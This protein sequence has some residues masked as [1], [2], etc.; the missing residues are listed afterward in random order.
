MKTKISLLFAIVF[1]NAS[2]LLPQWI[3]LDKN[4]PPDSKP[5]VHLISDDAAGTVIRVDLPG[6]R[7]NEIK[8][9]GKIYQSVEIGP[10]AGITSETGM[11]DIP[12]IAKILAIPDQGIVSVEVLEVGKK[13]VVEGINI[14]PARKSWIEGSPESPYLENDLVYHSEKLYPERLVKVEDPLIFRDFRIARVSIFPIQYSPAKQEIEAFST[15]TVRIKYGGG[16]GLNPKMTPDKPIAPSFDRLYKSIIFNYNEVLQRE[17]NG[18]VEGYDLMLCIMPDS[19]VTTFQQYADWNHKTGTFIHITKFSEIGAT[20]NNPTPIKDF[21]LNAYTSWAIPPTY[22]LLVGDA[23]VAPVKYITLDGWTFTYDD[24]FVELEG[25]D[26]I[27]ELMIGRFTNQGNV[28]LNI[29]ENKFIGYEKTPYITD[30]NWFRKGLVC[31]NDEYLSQILT[32]RFTAQE[33]LLKGNY[34]SVDSMYNGYP[35]PGNTTDIVNMINEGRGFLN[36]RGEGWYSG[37]AA[38]CFPLDVSDINSLS[39]GQKLTFVTSIGC[40][41]ANF[42]N[43]SANNFG[44]AWMEIGDV[45]APRGACAFL[46]PVSN[47]HTYYNNE[48][49]KGIYIGMFEEG[50]DSPGEAL[51][52]GKFRMYEIFGGAD[53]YVGYHYRIYHV[54]GDPSLHIWKDTP[55]NINV[56]YNDSIGVGSGEVNVTVTYQGSGLPVDGAKVCVSGDSVYTIGFTMSDGTAVLSVNPQTTGEL[57]FTVSGSNVIPFEG[58]IQV[59][60]GGTLAGWQWIET[61]Y[62]FTI[63][64]MSFPPGQSET[65]YAV[66]SNTAL[67]GIIL[68]TV[69]GG[70]T[71]SKISDDSIPGLRAVCFTSTETGFAGGYQNYLMK[72]TDGGVTWTSTS[73]ESRS[74]YINNIRFWD[75]DHGVLVNTPSIVFAT[76]DAGNTWIPAQGVK[77]TVEDI[78]YADANTL[79]IVGMDEMISRSTTGGFTW[80]HI[81]SG[82]P[83]FRLVGVDFYNHDYGIVG[84]E[85]GKMLVTTDGGITW[86]ASNAGSTGLMRGV[87]IL[88]EGNAFAA[89]T[90]EQVFKSTDSGITWISDFNGANTIEL[91]KLKFTEGSTGLICGSDGKFLI[92]HDYA[93]PVELTGFTA[94]VDGNNTHLNW[95]TATETNNSGFDILRSADGSSWKKIGFV[96]GAGTKSTTTNYSFQDQRL[97]PGSYFYKLKQIDYNGSYNFSDEVNVFITA[98]AKFILEQNYPNPFNPVT[99]IKFTIP[100]EVMVNLSVY[101]VVG[102]KVK[103]LKN[104][105]VKPGYYEVDFD[106]S[107]IA[108]GV[109]FYRLQAGDFT[110]TR[111]MNLIK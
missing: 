10:A 86:T 4:S 36:Y 92:N 29:M 15:I 87:N 79:Y 76:T 37:W 20:G 96:Q 17:H 81:Y 74:S 93:I 18:R 47:T 82:T 42:D 22:V 63:Y 48:I 39:N 23:G 38:G 97:K 45:S 24:Y 21:I 102:E 56:I 89:G 35:C 14:P 13:Q 98:P 46:G 75:S 40:G 2:T 12:Y 104:E 9:Q 70:S 99:T 88:D 44:E 106:A 1:L 25:N 101:N 65:G 34:I 107:N 52:R 51:L 32:K 11:P 68:K 110:R 58:T 30:P 41:V 8:D 43:G 85:N 67:N 7:L 100:A 94:A 49:D 90:P 69:D 103:E 71:W 33:M 55:K 27:P 73:R 28:R 5:D 6:F 111:K 50:L 3:S 61:G 60:P 59:T 83:F 64:D 62:P 66:G 72:T 16:V 95:T 108:S 19:F 91:N 84:G 57:D 53:F 78:C 31:S 77:Q 54:L 109:Y 26:F 80:V 105:V